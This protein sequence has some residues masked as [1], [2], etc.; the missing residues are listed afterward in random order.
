MK[1]I[2]DIFKV[3]SDEQRLRI[4]M[5]LKRKELCVC[6]LMGILGASQPLISRNLS[7]LSKAGFLDERRDGK[8][9][10]Y[11][12]RKN[13]GDDRRE[14]IRLLHRLLKGDDLFM[15]DQNTLK[16]CSEFQKLSGRCDMKTFEEFVKWQKSRKAA[17]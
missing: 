8:L 9:R 3:L 2:S 4:L 10:F 14:V 12:V 1:M 16:E 7:I 17:S 5:L 13:P 6:Q 11:S 15:D